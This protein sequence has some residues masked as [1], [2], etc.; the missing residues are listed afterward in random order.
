M[1]LSRPQVLLGK[2]A[3]R[4]FAP[5]QC[6]NLLNKKINQELPQVI[7]VTRDCYRQQL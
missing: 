2:P 5:L 1:I 7:V 6:R 4:V 3:S